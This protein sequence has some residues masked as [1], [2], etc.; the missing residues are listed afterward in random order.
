MLLW[1]L[2]LLWLL[3]LLLLWLLLLL[4]WLLLFFCT[5]GISFDTATGTSIFA[6]RCVC[7]SSEPPSTPSSAQIRLENF[8]ENNNKYAHL[9]FEELR[10]EVAK[11]LSK[12]R[13]VVE[14]AAAEV[15]L[16]I[17]Y[18][19]ACVCVVYSILV[20]TVFELFHCFLV[21]SKRAWRVESFD[22]SD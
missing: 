13:F 17:C 20:A 3:L 19:F 4:L 22:W 1:L 21:S 8:I 5:M 12:K 18:I 14:Q 7:W 11:L 6:H 15:C 10:T 16:L 2:W 9:T